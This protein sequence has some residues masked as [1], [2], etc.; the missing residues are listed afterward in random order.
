M[1]TME[2]KEKQHGLVNVLSNTGYKNKVKDIVDTC[3]SVVSQTLG[4][5]GKNTIIQQNEGVIKTK[6]GWNVLKA[7]K[8]NTI[9]DNSI[10]GI[11][12]EIASQVVLKVG[13]GSTSSVIAASIMNSLL[14]QYL[15]DKEISTRDL[16][17][18]L[19]RCIAL[20]ISELEKMSTK[21][22]SKD[23]KEFMYKIALVSTNWDI[24]TSNMISDIIEKTN[25]PVINTVYSG[26]D[27]TEIEI[28]EDSF[29]ISGELVDDRF[30]TN[31]ENSSCELI[32]PLVLIF[33]HTVKD[34]YIPMFISY[35][36][37]ATVAGVRPIVILAPEYTETF[38]N[39]YTRYLNMTLQRQG[40]IPQ[41]VPVKYI[42]SSTIDRQY[43]K[44]FTMMCGGALISKTEDLTN[45]IRTISSQVVSDDNTDSEDSL[46]TIMNILGS[47]VGECNEFNVSEKTIVIKGFINRNE[48]EYQR[49]LAQA[50]NGLDD[51]L[52]ELTAMSMLTTDVKMRKYRFGKLQCKMGTIKLGGFGN[53]DLKAKKDALDDA[54]RACESAYYNGYNIGSSM[55]VPIACDRLLKDGSTVGKLEQHIIEIIKDTFIQVFSTIVENKS[56]NNVDYRSTDGKM[57]HEIV[58]RCISIK[59]AYNIIKDD[60]DLNDEIINPTS[61]DVEILKGMLNI[62]LLN[63]TSNQ[64][65]FK[66]FEDDDVL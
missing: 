59:C 55:A 24:E 47:H 43:I 48:E 49:V 8:F 65:L 45:A 18:V 21:I 29:D 33:D 25:N 40:G 30:I 61:T 10:K 4:P 32:N 62:I 7:L 2:M 63:F 52:K 26:T 28:V 58:D 37:E 3:A 51:K 42:R 27:S 14:G 13:D 38:R 60:H 46:M 66:H 44:D 11:V 22:D 57:V 9:I 15:V 64:F 6:D 34:D 5:Y 20:V 31:N 53:A 12:E 17:T 35:Y 19:R 39:E 41:I 1:I 50:S 54:I 56:N 23:L 36:V 16:D